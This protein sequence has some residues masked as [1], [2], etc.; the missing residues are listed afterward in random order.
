MTLS[1][2]ELERRETLGSAVPIIDREWRAREDS[3]SAPQVRS[4]PLEDHFSVVLPFLLHRNEQQD[5]SELTGIQLRTER[6][7]V[8]EARNGLGCTPQRNCRA[9]GRGGA[10]DG[11]A[12]PRESHEQDKVEGH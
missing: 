6:C 10:A 1:N 9:R 12:Q 8:A 5:C 11:V 3:N 4:P 2:S 7:C